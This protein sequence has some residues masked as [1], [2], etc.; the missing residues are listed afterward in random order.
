MNSTYPLLFGLVC[1]SCAGASLAVTP[2]VAD[3]NVS[4][5]VGTSGATSGGS[6]S[7]DDLGLG[8]HETVPGV[9]VDA[10]VIVAHIIVTGLT[11]SMSGDGALSSNLS[12]G[13]VTIPAGTTVD[14]K[15]DFDTLSAYGTFD[16]LPGD[17]WELGLGMGL[18]GLKYDGKFKSTSGPPLSVSFDETFAVPVLVVSSAVGLGPFEISAVLAG[19]QLN[20]SGNDLTYSDVDLYAAWRFID[21]AVDVSIGLGWRR[22]SADAKFDSGGDRVKADLTFDGPYLGVTVGF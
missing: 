2:R 21:R 1:S 7:L 17:M 14:S 4:G 12:Q 13:G 6:T 18:T 3:L 9:R 5:H 11:T 22:L 19:M 10:D 20:Y 8:G 16:F 15:L